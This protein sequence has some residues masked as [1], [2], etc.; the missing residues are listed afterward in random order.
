MKANAVIG[1]CA[2]WFLL[3]C[4]KRK[5]AAP[6]E[7]T[8]TAI[9]EQ[10]AGAARA[11]NAQPGVTDTTW[12]VD[13]SSYGPV[14]LGVPLQDANAATGGVIEPPGSIDG[15]NTTRIAGGR[16]EVRL[17]VVDGQVARVDVGN[18]D[19]ETTRGAKIG[20]SEDRIRAL[21][22]EGVE[23]QP[24]KYTDGHYLIVTPADGGEFRLIFET[25]GALVQKYRA[26]VLPEVAWVEGCA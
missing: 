9:P 6:G 5:E 21:Y 22:P 7:G 16:A 19:V 15:C 20:D 24:H 13:F 4:G 12:L 8:G 18:G 14:P 25:D 23:V 3:G 11:E 2:L 1:F 10:S 17:M 26:G